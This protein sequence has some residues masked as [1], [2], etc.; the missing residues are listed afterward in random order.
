MPW[1]TKQ[2][3][4]SIRTIV[5]GYNLLFVSGVMGKIAS[6]EQ[7]QQARIRVLDRMTQLLTQSAAAKTI[8]VFDA[9][10]SGRRDVA[11]ESRHGALHVVIAK[12]HAEA[13]DLI[14]ELVAIHPLPRKLTVVSGDRRIRV[15]ARRRRARDVDSDTWWDELE[16]E[17]KSSKRPRRDSRPEKPLPP[18]PKD[19]DADDQATDWSGIDWSQLDWSNIDESENSSRDTSQIDNDEDIDFDDTDWLDVF[20]RPDD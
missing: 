14:E 15:A 7:L 16:R 1:T 4:A 20:T 8:V 19:L 6:G 17:E 3:L 9:P 2:R 10:K 12:R 5:D 18:N 11:E 13:D